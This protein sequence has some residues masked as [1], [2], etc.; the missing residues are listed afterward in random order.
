MRPRQ[1]LSL[2]DQIDCTEDESQIGRWEK[3]SP[4][5]A[6]YGLNRRIAIHCRRTGNIARAIVVEAKND[7]KYLVVATIARRHEGDR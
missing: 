5:L 1:I 4:I 6:T 7:A 3:Q 2:M